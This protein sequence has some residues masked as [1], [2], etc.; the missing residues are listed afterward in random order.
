MVDLEDAT[1]S[2]P[3]SRLLVRHRAVRTSYAWLFGANV[4]GD[5]S[6]EDNWGRQFGGIG[7][8]EM[9]KSG[10]E[11]KGGSKEFEGCFVFASACWGVVR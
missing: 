9:G 11:G 8:I 5:G 7:A 4:V 1:R 10:M 6:L 3:T 2:P